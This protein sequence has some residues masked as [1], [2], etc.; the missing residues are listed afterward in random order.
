[1]REIKFRV[2]DT[3]NETMRGHKWLLESDC[4]LSNISNNTYGLV[5]QYTGL[6]D[7]NGVEIYEGDVVKVASNN[8]SSYISSCGNNCEVVYS[9]L[10][11]GFNCARIGESE[12]DTPISVPINSK[13][14]IEVIGNIYENKDL[15]CKS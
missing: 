9:I 8:Y 12:V 2:W 15:L 6:H 7:K 10:N 13:M 3:E 4:Y 14:E 5:M 11:C 1:M